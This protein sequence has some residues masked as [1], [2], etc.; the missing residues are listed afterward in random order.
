M[1]VTSVVVVYDMACP[2]CSQIARELPDLVR[3]PVVVR[4]CRD[5]GLAET[6]P[7]LPAAVRACAAPAVGTVRHDGHVRW[8]LGRSGALALAPLVRPRDLPAAAR[9]L[10]TA[11]RARR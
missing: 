2:S 7:S 3:V 5:P 8:W 9:L 10:F 4:S 11:L 1:S 6:S